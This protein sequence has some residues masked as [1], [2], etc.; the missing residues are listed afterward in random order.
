MI[1]AFRVA[2]A[3]LLLASCA[4]GAGAPVNTP[5]RKERILTHLKARY[6]ELA[7]LDLELS[8]FS[9]VGGM[10]QTFMTMRGGQGPKQAILV[11]PDDKQVYMV[12]GEPVDASGSV[13]ELKAQREREVQSRQE[14]LQK[15]A[16][17]KPA[18]GNPNAPVTV[19]EFSDFQCP[20]C[21]RGSA[22]VEQLLQKYPNE[23]KVVFLH[24][25][26][27]FHPWAKPAAVAAECAGK[28]D[29][30]AFWT[31]HDAYFNDQ[32]A[33]APETVMKKSQEILASSGIDLKKWSTCAV[34]ESS[35]NKE[36]MAKVEA[37]M[38][39]G[40]KL[41]VDGTPAFFING[42]LVSGAVP[43]EELDRVVQKA[44]A[45]KRG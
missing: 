16:G 22:T 9:R 23:V 37:E 10:D 4:G 38:Q 43:L 20:Y 26:L 1:R 29:P 2:V 3:A 32:Q 18:R 13:A 44:L 5:E 17:S 34:E 40:S 39:A 33:F 8:D 36:M 24:Y 35:E 31:L 27:P 30:K 25:P 11:T 28:Q 21:K 45:Q 6:K 14:E 19:I 15:L 12:M 7:N 42:E 41:G